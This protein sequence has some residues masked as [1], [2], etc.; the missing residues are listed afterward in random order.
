MPATRDHAGQMPVAPAQ[1]RVVLVACDG[2]QSLDLTGPL[3][4]LH[5][6]SRGA[7]QDAYEKEIVTPRGRPVRS[8]SGLRIMPDRGLRDVRGRVDTLIVAGGEGARR[9]AAHDAQTVEHVRAIAATARRVC[10]VCTGAFVLAAAG[11]LDG[12]RATTHWQHSAT[13][14]ARHP[15][16]T[17]DPEPIFVRDGGIWTSAGV[18]AG[19]DLALA[20]VEEDLGRRVSLQV[21]RELVVFLQRPGG[22]AQFSAPLAAQRAERRALRELQAWIAEH[23][24]EDLGVARLA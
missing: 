22:Q 6:A 18:T 23:L 1:R 8:S 17:V 10:S 12:R 20:L 14:A 21:A 2:L 7:E 11:L 15:E 16:I 4:V 5:A 19:I 3:E 9:A 24:G 13:L